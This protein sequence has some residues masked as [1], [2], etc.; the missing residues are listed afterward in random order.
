M[1]TV[2][3]AGDILTQSVN[4]AGSCSVKPTGNLGYSTSGTGQGASFTGT[5]S[6]SGPFA[7]TAATLVQTTGTGCADGEVLTGV[8]GS[9]PGGSPTQFQLTIHTGGTIGGVI[10][11]NGVSI[12]AAGSYGTPPPNPVSVTGSGSCTGAEFN[13]GALTN[14]GGS[15]TMGDLQLIADGSGVT[16][17]TAQFN[18]ASRSTILHDLVLSATGTNNYW[19]GGFDLTSVTNGVFSHIDTT[20]NVTYLNSNPANALFIIRQQNN[21]LGHFEH[22]WDHVN[23]F[24]FMGGGV[25]YKATALD[26]VPFQGLKF[27]RL[28]CALGAHCLQLENLSTKGYGNIL[29]DDFYS[30]QTTQ[31][32]EYSRTG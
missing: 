10:Q 3:T 1:A 24:A 11:R 16:V 27:H 25:D 21:L 2:G 9:T 32:I 26:S 4:H 15:L 7:L 6:G 30:A 22:Y 8:G 18:M 28:S 29:I 13:I 12:T 23:A 19:G 31:Q 14:S 5:W 20:N 17:A